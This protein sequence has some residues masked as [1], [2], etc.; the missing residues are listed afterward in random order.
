MGRSAVFTLDE[1]A[2]MRDVTTYA[3]NYAT[4]TFDSRFTEFYGGS[5]AELS[6]MMQK[7]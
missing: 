1:I 7:I 5:V 6:Q 4:I 3:E 2:L